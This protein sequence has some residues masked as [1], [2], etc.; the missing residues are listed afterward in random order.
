M[1]KRGLQCFYF[2]RFPANDD[3][4]TR[5]LA[6]LEREGRQRSAEAVVVAPSRQHFERSGPLGQIGQRFR[7]ETW[8]TLAGSSKARDMVVLAAWPDAR[9]LGAIDDI[10]RVQAVCVLPWLED[11]IRVWR[12]AHGAV[13][14]LGEFPTAQLPRLDP[15]V[16]QALRS[17]TGMVNLSTGITHPSDKRAAIDTFESLRDSGY[18]WVGEWIETWAR[19]LGWRPSGAKDL[20]EIAERVAA[21]RSFRVTGQRRRL[22]RADIVD[23]WRRAQD[24][25]E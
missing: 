11:D 14:L 18:R 12:D 20:R 8:R 7:C 15:V 17:L 23:V 19:A 21:G 13:D 9:A 16:E 3:D 2:H 5:G 10:A 1:Q 22:L 25:D 6:W 24:S 4:L